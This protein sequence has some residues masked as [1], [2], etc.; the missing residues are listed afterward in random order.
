MKKELEKALKKSGMGH[1][2]VID[3]KEL[4]QEEQDSFIAGPETKMQM[5]MM[6]KD[7]GNEAFKRGDYEDASENYSG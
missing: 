5:V 6:L 3:R 7:Q 1:I 4:S 2:P